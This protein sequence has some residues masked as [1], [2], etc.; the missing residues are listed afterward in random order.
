MARN[1]RTYKISDLFISSWSDKEGQPTLTTKQMAELLDF[2]YRLDD[3]KIRQDSKAE[4]YYTIMILRLLRIDK[5]AV[6]RISVEQVVDCINDLTFFRNPW[7]FFPSCSNAYFESPDEYM[8]DRT[9]E[10][11]MYA[12]SAYTKYL[13]LQWSV[14]QGAI[15]S[16]KELNAYLDE[17]ITVIYTA[18]SQFDSAIILHTYANIREYIVKRYP[19]LFPKTESTGKE[20]QPPVHT[21]PMWRDLIFD[22]SETEAFKGFDK[23]RQA[24]IYTALDYLEKKTKDAK[25]LKLNKKQA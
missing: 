16:E 20:E 21:G 23:A 12:D 11:L 8:H 14:K 2:R 18:E 6:S 9:I 15:I 19:N 7:Y 24:R 5:S 25:E 13:V 4:G 1:K 22:F 10:Q 3:A 17:L